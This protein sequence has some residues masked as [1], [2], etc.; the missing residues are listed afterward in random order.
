MGEVIS[1]TTRFMRVS[2]KSSEF[3]SKAN[4]LLGQAK[5]HRR[6]GD[7]ALALELSYQS[8]LRAAGAVVAGSPVA[9]KKRKPSGAWDRLRMVDADAAVW[10]DEISGFSTLRSRVANGLDTDLDEALLDHFMA[11]VEKF[12]DEAERGAGWLPAVA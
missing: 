2:G 6:E 9:A 10:A 1:A 7:L 3:L 11:R 5:Q 4:V 8:A 12:L